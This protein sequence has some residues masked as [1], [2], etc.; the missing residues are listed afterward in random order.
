MTDISLP[1]E[2]SRPKVKITDFRW[3]IHGLPKVGKTSLASFFPNNIFL[4][5]EAGTPGMSVYKIDIESW[6]DMRK[7]VKLLV[8]EE[9]QF[10]SVTIDTVEIAY[11]LLMDHV[12]A[13]NHV[14]HVSKIGY[15]SGW[16]TCNKRFH[17]MLE[18]LFKHGL[19]VILCSHTKLIDDVRD[20]I[21]IQRKVPNLSKSQRE[22]TTGWV[23]EIL[24]LDVKEDRD[25]E[26]NVVGR[27]RIATCQLSPEVE[28]GGRLRHMPEFIPLPS[29]KEGFENLHAAFKEAVKKML[30]DY[31]LT[32]EYDV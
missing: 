18:D 19:G 25:E 11:K 17:A 1:A 24:Y 8:N 21:A 14:T 27:S 32:D 26:G 30:E 3:M 28:A 16:E 22:V 6:E 7:A 23:D 15:G 10:E 4:A 13:E 29:P 20:G 5:T 2:P 12:A 9:H 31:D